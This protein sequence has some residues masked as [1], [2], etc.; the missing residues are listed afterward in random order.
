MA[1]ALLSSPG[2]RGTLRG[3]ATSVGALVGGNC[4]TSEC[5]VSAR[6]VAVHAK[7][8]SVA[9][10]RCADTERRRGSSSSSAARGALSSTVSKYN[11]QFQAPLQTALGLDPQGEGRIDEAA[12]RRLDALADGFGDVDVDIE[13]VRS[14]HSAFVAKTQRRSEENSTRRR[15]S[16]RRPASRSMQPDIDPTSEEDDTDGDADR[17]CER[18]LGNVT[19]GVLRRVETKLDF[20]RERRA[21]VLPSI[22]RQFMRQ[23]KSVGCPLVDVAKLQTHRKAGYEPPMR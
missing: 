21:L 4:S 9:T 17:R 22:E 1:T 5:S 11:Q 23:D 20:F 12:R 15:L 18:V 14:R 7:C 10:L 2:R 6:A 3:R 8:H 16:L 19:G 13:G